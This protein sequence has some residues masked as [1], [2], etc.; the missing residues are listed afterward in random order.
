[1]NRSARVGHMLAAVVLILLGT[2]H[3]G[4]RPRAY[5]LSSFGAL[6]FTGTALMTLFGGILNALAARARSDRVLL[7]AT[8]LVDVLG[9]GYAVWVTRLLRQNQAWIGLIGFALA[10]LCAIYRSVQATR[11]A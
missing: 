6:W 5:P 8:S 4:F 7:W 11:R 9:L 10:A 2:A 1:M 3:L